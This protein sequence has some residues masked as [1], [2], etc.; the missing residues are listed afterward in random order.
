MRER[1]VHCI[2]RKEQCESIVI[3]SSVGNK[4][5]GHWDVLWEAL[6]F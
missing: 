2:K 5:E 6:M 1:A 4:N 3:V